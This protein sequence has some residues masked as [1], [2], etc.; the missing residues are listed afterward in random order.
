[1]FVEAQD[2]SRQCHS[3]RTERSIVLDSRYQ[4]W[5]T[6]ALLSFSVDISYSRR[7][8]LC[9]S[10][11]AM[12]TFVIKLRSCWSCVELVD[13]CGRRDCDHRTTAS[14]LLASTIS[15]VICQL[16]T[17]PLQISALEPVVLFR[18]RLHIQTITAIMFPERTFEIRLP[19]AQHRTHNSAIPNVALLSNAAALFPAAQ[20]VHCAAPFM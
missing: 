5:N 3:L 19:E 17:V 12:S 20:E 13:S 10:I 15:R 2:W 8:A 7:P 1:M 14:C 16:Q 6:L 11:E 4:R 9:R 18:T